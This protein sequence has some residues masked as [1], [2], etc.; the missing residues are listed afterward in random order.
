[1]E[2][3]LLSSDEEDLVDPD[4]EKIRI[5]LTRLPELSDGVPARAVLVHGNGKDFIQY[6]AKTTDGKGTQ[7]RSPV[8]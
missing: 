1:M 7:L 8:L 3:K 6:F 4:E 2:L 5:A